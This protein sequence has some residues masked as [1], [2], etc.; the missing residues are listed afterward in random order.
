[1]LG[2]ASSTCNNTQSEDVGSHMLL[3]ECCWTKGDADLGAGLAWVLWTPDGVLAPCLSSSALRSCS[4]R[5][6]G[7]G[8]R[9]SSL[10]KTTDITR[11]GA[12]FTK[13][14]SNIV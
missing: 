1:M 14:A 7:S 8:G 10:G 5:S 11:I 12:T 6:G 9:G 2:F 13:A 4:L 3:S